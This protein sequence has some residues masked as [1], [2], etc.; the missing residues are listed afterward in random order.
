[1]SEAKYDLGLVDGIKAEALGEPGQ[2][3]FRILV[4]GPGGAACLW[5]EKGLLSRLATA[6]R[7]VLMLP[8]KEDTVEETT[9]RDPGPLYQDRAS[10]EFKVGRLGFDHEPKGGLFLIQAHDEDEGEEDDEGEALLEFWASRPQLEGLAEEAL[11]VCAAGRPLCRLCSA[12]MGPE[13]HVCPRS[14]GHSALI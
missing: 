14:N 7:Q 10:M 6:I 9:L 2:R 3:Q 12:P 5:L 11:A 1:M 8:S 13:P 4:N